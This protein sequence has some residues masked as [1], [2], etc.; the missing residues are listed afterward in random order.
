MTSVA[1]GPSTLGTPGF[2]ADLSA[3]P[4]RLAG[5]TVA[6]GNFDGVHRGHQAVL[7]AALA[8]PPPVVA[9][10]FEPHPRTFFRRE[11]VFRLTPAPLKARIMEA[12]GLSGMVVA[13]FDEALAGM[14]AAR[15]IDEIL[16]GRLRARRVVVGHD[17][18]FG[19]GRS[20]RAEGL[21][22]AGAERG[23]SVTIVDPV[24]ESGGVVS[25]SRIRAHLGGGELDA[26]AA[27]LGY[28]YTVEAPV[29]HGEK[30]GRLMGYPTANQ[31]LPPENGLRHGI[32]AVRARIDGAWRD[33]V[34][35]FGRRP[36]FDNGRP[37]L[38]TFVFDYAGDLYGRTL[39]V[40]LVRYLRPELKFD[41]MDAL[42]A[43]MDRD[44]L[45][46]RIALSGL[47][48]LSPL[49]EALNFRAG[50]SAVGA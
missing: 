24:A 18:S 50:P 25:S 29:V 36:T 26:A 21:A 13:R 12:L 8:G 42:V 32:Y 40:T 15:F 47:T 44:S 28:R 48:P 46:A 39:P 49:D 30:R 20:G 27:L 17:F 41:G 43:Q 37:L 14:D 4:G 34:A 38:E 31:S 45:E 35:S 9:L 19:R 6:I 1:D 11:T 23:F 5:G 22:A 16:V 10:T 2:S 7:S 33:A 3:L